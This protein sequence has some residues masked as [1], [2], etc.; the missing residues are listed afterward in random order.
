MVKF[1]FF[2]PDKDKP[3]E[4]PKPQAQ[5]EKPANQPQKRGLVLDWVHELDWSENPFTQFKASPSHEFMV[6]QEKARQQIN[7]FFIQHSSFGT[8]TGEEGEGKTFMLLWIK[9][10]LEHYKDRYSV[11][12]FDSSS[13][14]EEFSK[15]LTQQYSSAKR[16]LR[17]YLKLQKSPIKSS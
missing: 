8:I 13:S 14:I 12:F 4:Q 16:Q 6:N 2:D 17:S 3:K 10:E 9:E 5:P 15:Q 1:T 7:L 11:Y